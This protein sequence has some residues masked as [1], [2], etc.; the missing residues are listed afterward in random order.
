MSSNTLDVSSGCKQIVERNPKTCSVCLEDKSVFY[1]LNCGHMFC[2]DCWRN[3]MGVSAKMD[4]D[5]VIT[6]CKCPQYPNC[7]YFP[8]ESAWKIL[9]DPH[10]F[11]RYENHLLSA[12]VKFNSDRVTF[13]GNPRCDR[14]LHASKSLCG[15][16]EVRCSVCGY[17]FCF[18]CKDVVH[19]P[20]TCKQ[21]KSWNMKKNDE[22]ALLAEWLMKNTKLCPKPGC[23]HR[24][25][26]NEGCKHMTCKCGHE[27][28]WDCLRPW[29]MHDETTGGF[30]RCAYFDP[31]KDYEKFDFAAVTNA[32]LES[33]EVGESEGDGQANTG[34]SKICIKRQSS[35]EALANFTFNLK[36][37]AAFELD[38]NRA[39][40]LYQL[41]ALIRHESLMKASVGKKTLKGDSRRI[42]IQ[43]RRSGSKRHLYRNF[44]NLSNDSQ[45]AL[46][47]AITQ[48]KKIYRTMKNMHVVLEALTA[49]GEISL[50]ETQ[51]VL[52]RMENRVTTV[53]K[54][55]KAIEAVVNGD[56]TLDQKRMDLLVAKVARADKAFHQEI[57]DEKNLSTSIRP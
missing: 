8:D 2:S 27:F 13:C 26:K 45:E 40:S 43:K 23:K 35:A 3:H 33:S 50:L 37:Y 22:E 38:Y 21:W 9:A 6:H 34:P 28:C 24:L 1:G 52:F 55:M 53:A 19:S 15:V 17:E 25:E 49:N 51:L 12:Y 5:L 31:S 41:F 47:Y 42:V 30:F 36:R 16:E 46:M 10:D 56:E 20:A 44:Q 57:N 54:L 48:V 18:R 7:N 32:Q 11:V 14:V 29:S 39:T 4:G